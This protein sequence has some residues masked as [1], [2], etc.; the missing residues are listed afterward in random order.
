MGLEK[1]RRVEWKE[2]ESEPLR[3]LRLYRRNLTG[4]YPPPSQVPWTHSKCL[5]KM[6]GNFSFRPAKVREFL[7]P[8]RGP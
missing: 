1:K 8:L 2:G 6:R 7:R 4:G 5:L 3:A